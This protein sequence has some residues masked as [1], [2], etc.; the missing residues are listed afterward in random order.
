M[1]GSAS[2]RARAHSSIFRLSCGPCVPAVCLIHGH[3]FYSISAVDDQQARAR[4]ERSVGVADL[5][6]PGGTGRWAPTPDA[7]H[8]PW[9]RLA[10]AAVWASP[11][12][13]GLRQALAAPR[14][15]VDVV[16]ADEA[17]VRR[18]VVRV[19]LTRGRAASHASTQDLTQLSDVDPG[20][21]TEAAGEPGAAGASAGAAPHPAEAAEG[22]AAGHPARA[23][24]EGRGVGAVAGEGSEPAEESRNV[25][26]CKAGP[27]VPDVVTGC[28]VRM[29]VVLARE[30]TVLSGHVTAAA[31]GAPVVVYGTPRAAETAASALH[32]LLPDTRMSRVDCYVRGERGHEMSGGRLLQRRVAYLLHTDTDMDL[33]KVCVPAGLSTLSVHGTLA[34]CMWC[35]TTR[36][37][38]MWMFYFHVSS[39]CARARYSH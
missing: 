3:F 15:A 14:P 18:L 5:T 7:P 35:S 16:P 29:V 23:S 20:T 26:V 2:D 17:G 11:R 38:E 33:N 32:A 28:R 22:E 25:F 6:I 1:D 36:T 10:L 4:F 13:E 19:G 9:E 34:P 31:V 24:S 37:C 27:K 12:W 39:E 30:D 21:Q 8:P